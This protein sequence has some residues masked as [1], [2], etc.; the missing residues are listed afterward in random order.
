MAII[1]IRNRSAGSH[2][3]QRWNNK[4]FRC[5]ATRTT[6]LYRWILSKVDGNI[7]PKRFGFRDNEKRKYRDQRPGELYPVRC[8]SRRL[9]WIPPIQCFR[10]SLC[11]DG[12]CKYVYPTVLSSTE[13]ET[14]PQLFRP[15]PPPLPPQFLVHHSAWIQFKC[16][17]CIT[18]RQ[19]A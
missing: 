1:S 8:H 3:N 11:Q 12:L 7:L 2:R 10:T 4:H 15:S 13:V 9:S 19:L 16:P 6:V 5:L 14:L 17:N 18:V